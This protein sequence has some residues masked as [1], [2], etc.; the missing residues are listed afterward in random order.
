M[1][2]VILVAVCLLG[3]TVFAEPAKWTVKEN[4]RQLKDGMSEK[5]VIALI[6]EPTFEKIT[7]DGKTYYYSAKEPEFN[8]LSIGYGALAHVRFR[9][10]KDALNVFV[11]EK[12]GICEPDFD[13]VKDI[14]AS[15]AVKLRPKH[16]LEAW[17]IKSNWKKLRIGL[18]EEAVLRI[19]GEPDKKDKYGNYYYGTVDDFAIVY[20]RESED[21]QHNTIRR[22]VE[23]FWYL[24]EK[25][26]YEEVIIEPKVKK[27]SE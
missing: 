15:K 12:Q 18:P 16:K 13:A 14:E 9:V 11:V 1:K 10:K 3:A 5:K 20:I 4:W 17:K 22:W 7:S 23:P 24:V 2:K 8:K 26:D 27:G 6:G 25:E 19:L 21:V